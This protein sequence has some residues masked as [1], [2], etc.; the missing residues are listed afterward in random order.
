[1][2]AKVPRRVAAKINVQVTVRLRR[3]EPRCRKRE[4]ASRWSR[5]EASGRGNRP[6]RARLCD[7]G[8]FSVR[9]VDS[10][11][12]RARSART[13]AGRAAAHEGDGTY[14]RLALAS[15]AA[16][17]ARPRP[18]RR[19]GRPSQSLHARSSLGDVDAH[20]TPPLETGQPGGSFAG[21]TAFGSE[22]TPG[23]AGHAAAYAPAPRAACYASASEPAPRAGGYAPARTRDGRP[24]HD[25]EQAGVGIR[26][27]QSQPHWTAG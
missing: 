9:V 18:D 2:P 1:V 10:P 15:A 11:G 3:R 6:S 20:F 24:G 21:R 8:R 27:S 12:G 17:V 19:P 7:G 16:L 14:R 26:R 13:A 5:N 4:T 22:S 25:R 23:A